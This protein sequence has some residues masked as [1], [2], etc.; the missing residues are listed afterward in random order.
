M[1][2]PVDKGS[3]LTD[4]G[5]WRTMD[6]HSWSAEKAGKVKPQ[7]TPGNQRQETS[8]A[9]NLDELLRLHAKARRG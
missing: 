8:I 5:E 9:Q 2:V 7:E 6:A 4:K 3:Q 1:C